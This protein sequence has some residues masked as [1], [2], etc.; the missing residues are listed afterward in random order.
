MDRCLIRHYTGLGATDEFNNPIAIYGDPYQSVC[1]YAPG[2]TS[3][4]PTNDGTV[5][6]D[7]KI[8]L[9]VDLPMQYRD[10][11]DLIDLKGEALADPLRF[12]VVGLPALGPSGFVV[13]VRMITNE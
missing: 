3:E 13:G 2:A 7:A 6:L 11:I 9:P 1:G 10:R 8:R 5:L 4:A 12:E